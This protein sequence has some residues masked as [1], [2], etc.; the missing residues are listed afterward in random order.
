[1]HLIANDGW[2][3]LPSYRFDPDTALWEHEGG[4]GEAP[5]SLMDVDYSNGAMQY[6]HRPQRD[7]DH[8]L[9][10]YLDEAKQILANTSANAHRPPDAHLGADFEH[11]RWFTL[12]SEVN[13][14]V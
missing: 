14:D 12:P 13:V 4:R 2:R 11:L 10:D 6:E 9:S 1:M 5:L 7:P 3:L 8:V